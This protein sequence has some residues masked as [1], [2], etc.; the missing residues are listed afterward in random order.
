[1]N[2][3]A[4]GGLPPGPRLPHIPHPRH[5]D[6]DEEDDDEDDEDERGGESWFAGGQRRYTVFVDVGCGNLTN[7]ISPQWH[8]DSKS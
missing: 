8:I 1:M 6:E 7:R 2:S 3:S 4:P 5:E